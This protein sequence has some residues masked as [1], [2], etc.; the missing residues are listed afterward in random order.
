MTTHYDADERSALR[1]SPSRAYTLSLAPQ[2]LYAHSRLLP[3]LVS[4]GA[5]EQLDF[6][7]IG[8][9]WL[10]KEKEEAESTSRGSLERIPSGREDVF[11]NTSLDVKAKRAL[12]KFLRSAVSEEDAEAQNW[13]DDSSTSLSEILHQKFRVPSVLHQP[14]LALSLS[15]SPAQSIAA[16]DVISRIRKHLSSIGVFGAGFGAVTA[17]YGGN[18]ELAQVGCRASA[19]GGGIYILGRGISSIKQSAADQISAEE[20]QERDGNTLAVELSDGERV[21][22]RWVVGDAANLPQDTVYRGSDRSST[23]ARSITIVSSGLE[24]LFPPTSESGPVPAGAVV[25]CSQGGES[26]AIDAPKPPVYLIVHSADT[27]EC[28]T[29]QCAYKFF[30]LFNLRSLMNHYLNTYLHCLQ[31]R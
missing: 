22:G 18:S 14:L 3:L 6:Q 26:K 1:L 10:Y 20:D 24:R 13:K 27:G 21:R 28:P 16:K 29:G 4:S 7:A 8:S 5:H 23:T 31:L 2:I 30:S 25:M 9:W 17:K 19:V 12:M 11:A 15:P